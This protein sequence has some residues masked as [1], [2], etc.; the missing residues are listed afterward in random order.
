MSIAAN[1]NDLIEYFPSSLACIRIDVRVLNE[2]WVGDAGQHLSEEGDGFLFE[3]LGVADVAEGYLFEGVA[4]MKK[5]LLLSPLLIL[6][7][8]VMA[9]LGTTPLTAYSALTKAGLT[10][11]QKKFS[12]LGVNY[13]LIWL[14][15]FMHNRSN[16]KA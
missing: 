4:C 10:S 5:Q 13:E 8:M 1:A 6:S 2:V 14:I 15:L 16:N 9:R 11:V 3:Q 7:L 12:F